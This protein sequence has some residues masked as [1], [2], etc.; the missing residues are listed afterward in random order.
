MN[1]NI[2]PLWAGL[3]AVIIVVIAAGAYFGWNFGVFLNPTTIVWIVVAILLIG[4]KIYS[5]ENTG[6]FY[7]ILRKYYIWHVVVVISIV[8]LIVELA[9]FIA[10]HVH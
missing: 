6:K 3:A 5:R 1:K 4:L 8:V 2:N 10:K 9:V 7:I